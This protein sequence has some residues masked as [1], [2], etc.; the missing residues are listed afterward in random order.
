MARPQYVGHTSAWLR[1]QQIR[2][3]RRSLDLVDTAIRALRAYL[4]IKL[5]EARRRSGLAHCPWK[6]LNLP[7]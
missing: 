1:A 5:R 4:K 2:D 7:G 3:L 6:S